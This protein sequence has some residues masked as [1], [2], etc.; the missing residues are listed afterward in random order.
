MPNV[1]QTIYNAVKLYST[2]PPPIWESIVWFESKFNPMAV[3]DNASSYGLFQLHIGTGAFG[4]Q[5]NIALDIIKQEQGLTGQEAITFL[6]KH[7]D[8]QARVGMPSINNAWERL[9]GTYVSTDTSW[10][11]DFCSLS[12]HPGGSVN[13]PTTIA[14]VQN[15]MKNV[16][17]ANLFGIQQVGTGAGPDTQAIQDTS[18]LQVLINNPPHQPCSIV[19]KR[20]C[21][22]AK[23]S[24]EG[25]MDLDSPNGTKVYSLG[26][27][28]IIGAGYF[29]HSDNSPGYGVVTIR[30][31]FPD[32]SIADIYYQHLQLSTNIQLCG[33]SGGQL[34]G[35]IV[36]PAPENQLVSKGQ[37]LGT[38]VLGEC[39]VGINAEWGGIWGTS[40][41]GPWVDDP[42][43]SIRMLM[44][45]GGGTN[46][47]SIS[48]STGNN[49][50]D[51]YITN[52]FDKQLSGIQTLSQTP[53][54]E[55]PIIL[56]NNAQQFVPFAVP[57]DNSSS[58]NWPIWGGIEQ[59]ASY[60]TRVIM[61]VVGFILNNTMA[62]IIRG[63]FTIFAIIVILA[64]LINLTSKVQ[65]E[66]TDKIL[67]IAEMAA[68][69]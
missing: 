28:H 18:W 15:F 53:G 67:P 6:L 14:Y 54:L 48:L 56:F 47:N 39:E 43:D 46:K 35:G 57:D 41:P 21:P 2:V 11:L 27:G 68:M 61:G 62:F 42:E 52:A 20:S 58:K 24:N 63:I 33:Q 31:T 22:G 1:P 13:D 30:T 65:T 12:G 38:I 5:G 3:G 8:L 69:A 50:I 16:V 25:G 10:W 45:S 17:S 36:G 44:T 40:H 49:T 51:T 23:T 55:G 19:W 7:A 4:G 60:P 29:Y 59:G 32:G 64:L 66:T 26:D 9:K 34:Y 37:F